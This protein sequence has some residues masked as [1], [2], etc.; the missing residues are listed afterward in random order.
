MAYP[1]GSGSERLRRGAINTQSNTATA[2]RWDSTNPTTGTSSYVVP[3]L[4]ICILLNITFCNI[5]ATDNESI[6]M[7]YHTNSVQHDVLMQQP[8]SAKNTYVWN[9][10]L[11]L[12]AGDAI[13]VNLSSAG[14]VDI[15]YSFIDQDWS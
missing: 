13:K 12:E 5:H 15:V 14:T 6:L 9:D 11:V 7:E 3:A 8:L 10:R 1:T 4:H 2:L